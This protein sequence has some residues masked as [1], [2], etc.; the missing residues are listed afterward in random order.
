MEGNQDDSME[1]GLE[2]EALG[3]SN[4]VN[5]GGSVT[6]LTAFHPEVGHVILDTNSAS[7][8]QQILNRPLEK[9][10]QVFSKTPREDSFDRRG[11]ENN[12]AKGIELAEMIISILFVAQMAH[13]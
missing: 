3:E 7:M 12:I 9:G 11:V 1:D 4:E 5:K 2:R 13:F 6:P 8:I 10:D